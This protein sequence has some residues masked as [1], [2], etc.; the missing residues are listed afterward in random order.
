MKSKRAEIRESLQLNDNGKVVRSVTN[1]IYILENDPELEGIF[2]KNLLTDRIDVVK[3]TKWNSNMHSFDDDDLHQVAL[4]MEEYG[5]I[6]TNQMIDSGIRI[7]AAKEKY[8]PIR[9]KLNS[10]VWDGIP[11]VSSA[12]AHFLGC[13]KS[14]LV[15]ESLKIFMLG[16]VERVFH[17]GCKFETMLCLVGKQGDGKSTFF[18]LLSIN[19][20]WFSDDLRRLDDENV[21]RKMN[22]HWIIE[23]AEMV[24]TASARYIEENKA[25]ISRQ[26]DT[27]KV[28]YEKYPKDVLRQCVFAGSSNKKGFL[29]FDRTG[30]RRFI[31]I[32][33]HVVPPEVHIL[34]N[35]KESRQYIEQMW[36]EIMEI[37]KSGDYSLMLP[38]H[39]EEQLIKQRE[40]YMAEDTDV[41]II[42]SYL[43][44]LKSDYVCT[45]Q[46]YAEALDNV[47]KPD[48]R[49]INDI[50][51]IM[52][53]S[54]AGWAQT[55]GKTKRFNL[56]GTQKYWYRVQN[57]GTG[58]GETP[59]SDFGDTSVN[60][61]FTPIP[62]QLEI[63]FLNE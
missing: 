31:P 13:E 59:D 49:M 22:G 38:K 47:G 26:K 62:E 50:N 32:E 56:Y 12:L 44:N 35:E 21:V 17:P 41:G 28:P 42:Q 16:A 40:F 36:A 19:D 37:Y 46:I 33:T 18:R 57:D 45:N 43:D 11:R 54:I 3:E 9:D 58:V 27:Y 2:R 48:R 53:N 23:M 14:E 10:L 63:P 15:Y 7:V 1:I 29:P 61:G 39:L 60:D 25:F 6:N 51:D 55:V 52:N 30:N 5:I 4:I 8:H 34:E 24:A 20:E